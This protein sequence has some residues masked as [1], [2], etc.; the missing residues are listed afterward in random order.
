MKRVTVVL[1][2]MVLVLGGCAENASRTQKGAGYGALGGAAVGA[3]LGALIGHDAHGAA[4][5]AAVGAGLGAAAGAG[6]GHYMDQQEAD[7]RNA[8][9]QSDSVNI[10]RNA[11]LLSVSFKGDVVFDHNST[12]IKAGAYNEL[13]RVAGV[14]NQYPQTTIVVAGHTDSV[15]SETYNQRLSERRA[16]AA[17][18]VLV[19]QGVSPARISTIGYGETRPIASNS[20]PEGRQLNR[21]VEITIA[22][23]QQ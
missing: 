5:G 6:V 23:I 3:G 14:L 1:L 11:N 7:M 8:L 4:I 16:D 9:A 18:N 22:P 21:R 20:T 10:Q 15:G 12:A 19:A 17:R 13:A 2:M